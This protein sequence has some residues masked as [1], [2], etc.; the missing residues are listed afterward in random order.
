MTNAV[1]AKWIREAKEAADATEVD[2]DVTGRALSHPALPELGLTLS[3]QMGM[4]EDG[5]TMLMVQVGGNKGV[6]S[7]A[8]V[9]DVTGRPWPTFLQQQSFGEAGSWSINVAGRPAPPLSLALLVTGVGAEVEV[10][11]LVEKVPVGAR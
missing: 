8:Q 10:P 5:F 3:F 4:A 6:L 1:P 2:L 9:F 7:D 11:I